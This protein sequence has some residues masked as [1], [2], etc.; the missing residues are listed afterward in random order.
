MGTATK[1]PLIKLK[2][3]LDRH[4]GILLWGAVVFLVAAGARI[5]LLA[6]RGPALSPD[7]ADYIRLAE[8]IRAHGV[9]SLDLAPPF[10][11]SI[12][13]PPLYPFILSALPVSESSLP[14]WTALLQAL[15]DSG[16]AV[17]VLVLA[18]LFLGLRWATGVGLM[19]A[20]FP[21]ALYQSTAI[22]TESLF[23][24]LLVG[25]VLATLGGLRKDRLLFTA[26]GGLLLGLAAL[27]RPIALPLPA[28]VAGVSLFSA[29]LLRRRCSHYLVLVACAA[30]MTAPWI[31][32]ATHVSNELVLIQGSAAVNFYV[33]TLTAWDQKDQESLWKRFA[34][35]DPYG[36]RLAAARNPHEVVEAD[37]FGTR[38]GLQNVRSNPKAYIASRIKAF[39]YLF[40]S[41]FDSFTG[42]NKS[43]QTLWSQH[44]LPRL[45]IKTLLM[46][47]FS[48]AP[49]F[50]ALIGL[51]LGR[52]E[53]PAMVVA[54]IWSYMLA[55]N[56]P[57]WVEY[58]FWLPAVPFLFISAAQGVRLLARRLQGPPGQLAT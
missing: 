8:N 53:L 34:D 26:L 29:G 28:I 47:L 51:I 19:Y 14:K 42:I 27:C 5:T 35:E 36:R 44:D 55:A 43:F 15:L 2:N 13:R 31:V 58:R 25:G 22:L 38:L 46:L 49:F 54:T 3:C 7:S 12:R 52:R 45:A 50:F 33:T 11:P 1:A 6:L 40:I 41:S 56:I 57:M 30:I 39:P 10:T 37:R 4:R 9:F 48:A 17:M 20:F 32:R 16:T 18:S 24:A 21:G 23:T